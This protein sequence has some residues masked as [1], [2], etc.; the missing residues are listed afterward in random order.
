MIPEQEFTQGK[1]SVEAYLE[2]D[3]DSI[4]GLDLTKD[5]GAVWSGNASDEENLAS[6]I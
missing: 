4:D 3:S 2:P 6:N 5:G 1:A